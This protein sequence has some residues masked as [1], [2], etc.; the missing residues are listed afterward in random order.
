[1]RI[2]KRLTN[3][4]K[5]R[6]LG[7]KPLNITAVRREAPEF[8]D[9]GIPVSSNTRKYSDR[10]SVIVALKDRADQNLPCNTAGFYPAFLTFIAD[11]GRSVM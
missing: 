2:P 4:I 10:A 8:Q 11:H 6:W 3:P 7:N 5:K 1:M 9:L